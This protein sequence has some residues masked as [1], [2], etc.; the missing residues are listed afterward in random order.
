M[1]SAVLKD[2]QKRALTARMRAEVV[3][4]WEDGIVVRLDVTPELIGQLLK[5]NPDH[6]LI[7]AVGPEVKHR[8]G[9]RAV[10]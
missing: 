1:A 5:G 9:L 8:H 3:D 7:S 6:L 4:I 2:D 10:K